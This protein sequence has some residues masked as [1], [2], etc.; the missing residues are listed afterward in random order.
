MEQL[1][2]PLPGIAGL[3][4]G[5]LVRITAAGTGPEPAGAP[6]ERAA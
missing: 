4:I 1:T 3:F 2:L 6:S 5:D